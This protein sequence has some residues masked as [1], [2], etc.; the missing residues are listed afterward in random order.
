MQAYGGSYSSVTSSDN[1]RNEIGVMR[2][3]CIEIAMS[4]G[5]EKQTLA[6]TVPNSVHVNDISPRISHTHEQFLEQSV[7]NS[8][9]RTRS[10]LFRYTDIA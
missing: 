4:D 1:I 10:R 9:S 5:F 2:F 7:P 6:P 3:P 8:A